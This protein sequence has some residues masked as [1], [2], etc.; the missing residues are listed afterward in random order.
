MPVVVRTRDYDSEDFRKSMGSF[1]AANN[2]AAGVQ[3]TPD[4]W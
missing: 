4:E 3:L 2:R 1:R